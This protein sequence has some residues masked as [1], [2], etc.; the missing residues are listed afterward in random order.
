MACGNFKNE[1]HVIKSSKVRHTKSAEI[2]NLQTTS[3]KYHYN[4]LA[5]TVPGT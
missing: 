1:K 4:T 5:T 3:T 2:G